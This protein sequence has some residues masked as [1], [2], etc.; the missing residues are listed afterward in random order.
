MLAAITADVIVTDLDNPFA[1]FL[2]NAVFPSIASAK[3][4]AVAICYILKGLRLLGG[5]GPVCVGIV[6]MPCCGTA[7]AGHA[8][9]DG[10][11]G[12]AGT[13]PQPVGSRSPRHRPHHMT[14]CDAA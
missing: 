8:N 7:E 13:A 6:D 1:P 10:P 3:R 11:V 12:N 4:H 9:P 14:R 2:L 5:I